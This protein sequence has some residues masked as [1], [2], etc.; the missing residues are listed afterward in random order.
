MKSARQTDFIP[1]I[2][3]P[4]IVHPIRL[5]IWEWDRVCNDSLWSQYLGVVN[6]FR[7]YGGVTSPEFEEFLAHF[8]HLGRYKF[9][10]DR[11]I[12]ASDADVDDWFNEGFAEEG[13]T[14]LFDD[15][16]SALPF[17]ADQMRVNIDFDEPPIQ[18]VIM[19]AQMTR[20]A[21]SAPLRSAGIIWALDG[22][23]ILHAV[24][25]KERELRRIMTRLDVDPCQAALFSDSPPD[26]EAAFRAG[27]GLRI[28]VN[29]HDTVLRDGVSE[30]LLAASATH[31]ITS[32]MDDSVSGEA[33]HVVLGA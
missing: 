33:A 15:F 8:T 5:I 6:V 18:Q 27:I 13:E 12:D 29:R 31:I 28:G 23:E 30:R 1:A 32:L 21:V 24:S 14:R 10:E 9:F 7:R 2:V 16:C 11:T 3:Q 25:N 26:M 22:G 20:A 4:S 19:T 17:F